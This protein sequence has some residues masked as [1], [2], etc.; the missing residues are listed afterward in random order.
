MMTEKCRQMQRCP[1][2]LA[3]GTSQTA[4]LRQQFVQAIH[5]AEHRCR[6]DVQPGAALLQYLDQ[7]LLAGVDGHSQWGEA[8]LILRLQ[9]RRIR[10]EEGTHFRAVT[11][12]DSVEQILHGIL[13]ASECEDDSSGRT[14]FYLLRHLRRW[15]H[16]ANHELRHDPSL[17]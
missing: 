7:A 15:S 6:E 17:G 14:I 8:A 4:I 5:A 11:G 16:C 1:A 12:F 3:I 13:A 9:E 2:V 10:I